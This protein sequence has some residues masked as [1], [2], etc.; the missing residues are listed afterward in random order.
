MIFKI[1]KINNNQAILPVQKGGKRSFIA[2][3]SQYDHSIVVP[4]QLDPFDILL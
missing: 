3:H 4:Y 1:C 2:L